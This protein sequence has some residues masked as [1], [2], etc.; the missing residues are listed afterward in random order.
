VPAG[1]LLIHI[2][3]LAATHTGHAAAAGFVGAGHDQFGNFDI[4]FDERHPILINQPWRRLLILFM[5]FAARIDHKAPIQ[6]LKEHY[7]GQ[8]VRKGHSGH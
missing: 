6:L 8:A 7:P 1:K 2:V 5:V 3:A 4:V